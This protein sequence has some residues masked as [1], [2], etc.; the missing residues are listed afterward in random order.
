M[1]SKRLEARLNHDD[2]DGL[3]DLYETDAVF[4]DDESTA[5]GWTEIKAAHQRFLTQAYPSCSRTRSCSKPMAH[6]GS[7]STTRMEGH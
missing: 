1:A 2:V 7:S 6:G 5:T 4:A 3:R